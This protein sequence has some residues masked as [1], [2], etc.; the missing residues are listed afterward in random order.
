MSFT[1]ATSGRAGF[2]R[3]GSGISGNSDGTIVSNA[4]LLGLTASSVGLSNVE[5]TAISTWAGNTSITSLGTVTVGSA[6]ASD[7]YSWAK[8]ASKPTYTAS[9]VGLGNVNNESKATMFSSP[10]FT[11]I[12]SAGGLTATSI[13]LSTINAINFPASGRITYGTSSPTSIYADNTQ[14]LFQVQNSGNAVTMLTAGQSVTTSTGGTVAINGGLGVKGSVY[15]QNRI[16][17]RDGL[18]IDNSGGGAG[19]PDAIII[20]N[21]GGGGNCATMNNSG[22]GLQFFTGNTSTNLNLYCGVLS[23]GGTVSLSHDAVAL[24]DNK[25]FFVNNIVQKYDSV[26]IVSNVATLNLA[27]SNKFRIPGAFSTNLN[28]TNAPRDTAFSYLNVLTWEV[29]ID[30]G[31]SAYGINNVSV[32]GSTVTVK[33]LGG[34]APAVTANRI[35]VITFTVL[36]NGTYTLLARLSSYG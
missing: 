8:A 35:E 3:L 24:S 31:S 29:I 6:P 17:V 16:T 10:T 34:S 23:G 20:A 5:N 36:Y 7:V 13:T 12:T 1:T 18:T 22:G 2:V 9:E 21:Y 19:S 32:N 4:T 26:S 28:F 33:W 14:I 15:V 25:S 11:G 27:V 30:Q